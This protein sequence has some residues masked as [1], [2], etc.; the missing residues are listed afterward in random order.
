[1]RKLMLLVLCLLLGLVAGLLLRPDDGTQVSISHAAESGAAVSGAN[2]AKPLPRVPT[3][4]VDIVRDILALS[5]VVL[6]ALLLAPG[7]SHDRPAGGDRSPAGAR[8]GARRR[9]PRATRAR[10]TARARRRPR[11]VS[12]P[13]SGPDRGQRIRRSRATDRA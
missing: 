9:A 1:M 5:A 13:S 12:G 8:A 2:H 4:D 3:V 10:L 11:V 6:A 7:V